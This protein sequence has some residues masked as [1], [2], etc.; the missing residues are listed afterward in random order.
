MVD[1]SFHGAR[2]EF[3]GASEALSE[4]ERIVSPTPY[5]KGRLRAVRQSKLEPADRNRVE[6]LARRWG[7]A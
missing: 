6:A 7:I 4:M 1:V 2:R 3:P 5:A